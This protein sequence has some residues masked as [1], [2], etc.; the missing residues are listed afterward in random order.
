MF[1][2]FLLML[3]VSAV[4]AQAAELTRISFTID[5]KYRRPANWGIVFSVGYGQMLCEI[6]RTRVQASY[7]TEGFRHPAHGFYP[8][9]HCYERDK[10]DFDDERLAA[11]TSDTCPRWNQS[12]HTVYT[13]DGS[14]TLQCSQ[15]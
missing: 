6:R 11:T 7:D 3:L 12:R 13:Y 8:D 2:S 9:V 4:S 10:V 15:P 5:P 1:R 14:R